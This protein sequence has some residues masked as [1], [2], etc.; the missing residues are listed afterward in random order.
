MKE[1]H[2]LADVQIGEID[3][4]L[5]LAARLEKTPEPQAFLIRLETLL[6]AA[7]A[8]AAGDVPCANVMSAATT[9][10]TII[11]QIGN[12]VEGPALIALN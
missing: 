9:H 4:L 11:D 5:E 1:F 6:K 3:A 8:S 10:S 7:R 12:A 2:D